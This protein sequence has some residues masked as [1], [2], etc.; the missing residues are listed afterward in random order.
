MS[1]QVIKL[2]IDK[3][4]RTKILDV[5]NGGEN[6]RTITSNFERR[7]G[8]VNEDSRQTTESLYHREIEGEREITLG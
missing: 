5:C 4:G 2:R 7:L 8:M 3:Q 1:Q 6:C